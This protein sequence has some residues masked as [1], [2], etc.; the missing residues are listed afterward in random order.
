MIN[1]SED[2]TAIPPS[3][4]AET[5]HP[6]ASSDGSKVDGS[7]KNLIKDRAMFINLVVLLF[8]WVA[9]AFDYYLIN[10][11]LKYIDGDIY[12]NTIVSSVSEVTAY[13]ISGALYDR[14]GP[15]ISFVGSFVIGIIGS[16]FYITLSSTHKGLVPLMVLGSKFG[17]SGSF[18]VV[19]L[20]NG[21]FPPV[22][23]STTFGLCNFFAR[24]A[25][26]IA[27]I[28]AESKPPTPMLVFCVMAA[29]AA[30]VSMLLQTGNRKGGRR[31]RSFA[32]SVRDSVHSYTK[33]KLDEPEHKEVDLY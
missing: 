31:S 4:A 16:L 9:S 26:M 1:R 25:S 21:L 29:L 32:E 7:I 23:S 6:A 18:N 28:L 30:G 2:R 13:I 24:L 10:F 15:K 12:V 14:I 3:P 19:Y 20:A 5:K 8:L 22:Y 33:I 11:Q 27:P 17:I